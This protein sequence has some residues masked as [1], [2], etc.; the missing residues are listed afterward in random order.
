[1]SLPESPERVYYSSIL[2]PFDKVHARSEQIETD[3]FS[4]VATDVE[5]QA[6]RRLSFAPIIVERKRRTRRRRSSRAQT[7]KQLLWSN[8]MLSAPLL[9]YMLLGFLVL[10]VV[11]ILV[12]KWVIDHKIPET[13]Q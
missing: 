7:T 4:T 6:G 12:V 8:C 3:R 11:V 1:M 5:C 9:I 2:N 13:L 10:V